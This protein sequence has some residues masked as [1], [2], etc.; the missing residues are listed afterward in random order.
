MM[1]E[2]FSYDAAAINFD[3]D[4]DT[5][6]NH[7]NEIPEENSV[8]ALRRPPGGGGGGGSIPDSAHKFSTN[9]FVVIFAI[10]FYFLT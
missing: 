6:L 3:I 8:D 10:L 2:F 1:V 5:Q 4:G 9:I 7:L